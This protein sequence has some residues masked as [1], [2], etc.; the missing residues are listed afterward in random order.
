MCQGYLG[1]GRFCNPE[2]R[3]LGYLVWGKAQELVLLTNYQMVLL[4]R[5]RADNQGVRCS[6]DVT[7][8]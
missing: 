3:A 2:C 1:W 7:S 6:E 4:G 8:K 5:P